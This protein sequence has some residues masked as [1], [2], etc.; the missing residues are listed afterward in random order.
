MSQ[1]FLHVLA[2]AGLTLLA[3][4][5][6]P[7]TPAPTALPSPVPPTLT[8]PPPTAAP[9]PT[10]PPA[11]TAAARSIFPPVGADEW[12]KGSA[13]ARLTIIEYADYQ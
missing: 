8:P 10:Q 13:D 9:A 4:C 7:A 2:L 1:R 3:A 5:A 11:P 6:P 12:Q